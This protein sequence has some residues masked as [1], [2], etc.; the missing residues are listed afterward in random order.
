MEE[1]YFKSLNAEER[2]KLDQAVQDRFKYN[3]HKHFLSEALK[4][5]INEERQIQVQYLL[6][7]LCNNIVNKFY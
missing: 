1:K 6:K 7:L 2:E 3:N 4:I 5:S